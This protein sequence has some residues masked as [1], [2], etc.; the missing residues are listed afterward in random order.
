MSQIVFTGLLLN[1]HGVGP[2]E[3]KV[4]AVRETEP[5]TNVAELRSFLGLISFSSRFLR[6]FVTTA[7]P[8]RTLTRQ[9]IKWKWGGQQSV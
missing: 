3:E 5:P 8:L 6:N 9:N 2:T 7:Q 4:R 1:K